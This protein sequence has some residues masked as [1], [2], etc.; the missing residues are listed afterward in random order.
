MGGSP[1]RMQKIAELAMHELNIKL[2]VGA[3]LVNL[4]T[5]DRYE[6][7]KAGPVLSVSVRAAVLPLRTPSAHDWLDAC[8]SR[9]HGR[10]YILDVFCAA[11]HGL[12]QYVH[13]VA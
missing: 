4:C 13:H 12:S 3:S 6:L 9:G 1:R 11:W 7:Y 8:C 2:P 5:T 10:L